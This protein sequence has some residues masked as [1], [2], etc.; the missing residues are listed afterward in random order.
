MP[1]TLILHAP[2]VAAEAQA[3]ADAARSV[4]FS[5]VDVR[6][7]AD[8]AAMDPAAIAAYDALVLGGRAADLA[9]LLDHLAAAGATPALADT[10]GAVF[11]DDEAAMWTVLARLGRLGFL[12]VG[13][14]EAATQ[15]RRVA[16]VAEWVR[17]AKSHQHHH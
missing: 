12:L 3:I 17:H 2:A 14:A 7:V 6:P 16:T 9:P 11:G 15:G 5:E 8:G 10:V 1:K 13:P 4:R